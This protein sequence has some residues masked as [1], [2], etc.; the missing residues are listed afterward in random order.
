MSAS[1]ARNTSMRAPRAVIVREYPNVPMVPNPV[2]TTWSYLAA[3]SP[4]LPSQPVA[5][6]L[7]GVGEHVEVRAVASD[8]DLAGAFP[9]LADDAGVVVRGDQ[10]A[11]RVATVDLGHLAQLGAR[12]GEPVALRG[13][14]Q[15]VGVVGE[16]DVAGLV[17]EAA[18]PTLDRGGRTALVVEGG[19]HSAGRHARHLREALQRHAGLRGP[20]QAQQSD[21][22]DARRRGAE[23]G[24]HGQNVP[25]PCGERLGEAVVSLC[26]T[27]DVRATAHVLWGR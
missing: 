3:V 15:P 27:G 19:R 14:G 25:H 20:D 21:R 10:V 16:G 13:G 2:P 22:Q 23:R 5:H 26:H 7:V 6:E 4:S 17:A 9:V 8:R 24:T 1:V 18:R 11:L 12:Q